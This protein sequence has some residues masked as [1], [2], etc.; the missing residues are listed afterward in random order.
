[1]PR[2]SPKR[3]TPTP[4]HAVALAALL[5]AP[6]LL[7][8]MA[9]MLEAAG[10]PAAGLQGRV[11][12]HLLAGLYLLVLRAFF[13]DDTTDLAKTMAALDR[14]LRRLEGVLGLGQPEA[15]AKAA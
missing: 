12:A 10:V 6:A 3:G 9:W 15:A 13:A 2:R 7:H 11:R 14:A 4:R 8:S 1:M 5:G